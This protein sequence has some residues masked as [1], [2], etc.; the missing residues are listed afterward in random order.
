MS[1][2]ESYTEK[3]AIDKVK[4]MRIYIYIFFFLKDQIRLI[5]ND[6]TEACFSVMGV[7]DLVHNRAISSVGR[8]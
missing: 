4:L 8:A 2:Y 3:N 5:F 1:S 6:P 7:E